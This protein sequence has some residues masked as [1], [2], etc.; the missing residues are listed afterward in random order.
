MTMPTAAMDDIER[1]VR[2]AGTAGMRP[3]AI[4]DARGVKRPS[5][6][7]P[8][9]RLLKARRLVSVRVSYRLVLLYAPE[10]APKEPARVYAP[11]RRLTSIRDA[12]VMVPQGDPIITPATKV[13]VCPSGTDQRFTFS[14]PPGW[15]GQITRD[16]R[17]RRLGAAR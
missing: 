1:I 5:V 12:N 8:L 13:T 9:A 2:A 7:R 6:E 15:V 11:L 4:A 17:E 16:W 3:S 10:H 14:P